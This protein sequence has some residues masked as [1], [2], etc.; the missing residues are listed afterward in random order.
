MARSELRREVLRSFGAGHSEIAELMEYGRSTFTGASSCP[1]E[2]LPLADD[3]A[4]DSW[5]RYADEAVEC[6][7]A[8]TLRRSLIQLRFP[9]ARGMSGTEAYQAATRRG[10]IDSL[11]PAS[12]TAF[13]QPEG[14]EIL[15]HPTAAGH[16]PVIVAAAREDFVSLIHA[17]TR[18]N[19]PVPI[20][21]SMGACIL[22][23][24]NNWDRVS[25]LRGAWQRE[26]PMA[27]SR[28][29]AVA[30][31]GL[32][33][34]RSLYQDCFIVLSCGPYSATPATDVGMPEDI[35]RSVSHL[36]R[37]EHECAHYFTRRVLGSMR[38]A[39]IDEL[40]AD[41]VGLIAATGHYRAGWVERFLG[42]DREDGWR[43]GGRLEA[44]RGTPA[45]SDGA[46]VVL[47]RLVRAAVSNLAALDECWPDA[48][49]GVMGLARRIVTL[50]QLSV[51]E[52]A[53]DD[54]YT[55][56]RQSWEVVHAGVDPASHFTA[57]DHSNGNSLPAQR[58]CS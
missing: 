45:L 57:R 28:D 13:V 21:D 16:V 24:Y 48:A 26:H 34:E 1:W 42:V 38:N 11:A 44:Y 33:R 5:R 55:Y 43:P 56:V 40:I 30:F 54:A 17:L 58:G 47:C 23:G 6:G 27:T 10:V 7:A 9:I 32:K 25:T 37:L 2:S 50:S 53:C 29:W 3:P 35:W 51:E 20:P 19:E 18:R 15:V 49:Y 41:H 4:V 46:F 14:I 36:I 52:L 31:D 39:L 12:G 8:A 22:A